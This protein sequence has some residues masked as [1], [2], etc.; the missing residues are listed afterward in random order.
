V[1]E[2]H[3]V[4][5]DDY[6]SQNSRDLKYAAVRRLLPAKSGKS[7]LDVGCG[8]RKFRAWVPRLTYTGIDLLDGTD[9][10]D[11]ELQHDYV[12]ANGVVYKLGA[13]WEAL[14]LLDHCWEL[15]REAFVFTSLDSWTHFHAEELTLDPADV[16]QWA[17]KRASRVVVDCSYKIG[18]FAVLMMR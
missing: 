13:E 6:G 1:T 15:A 10:L 3:R 11:F 9:V 2:Y 5:G 16:L 7:L 14:R 12:V 18:D 4:H 17:R 8:T